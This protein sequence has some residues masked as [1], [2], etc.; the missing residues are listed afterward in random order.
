MTMLA[1]HPP[2]LRHPHFVLGGSPVVTNAAGQILDD[3]D[4]YPFGGERVV[5]S[6]SGNAYKFTGKERDAESGLDNFGL[7]YNSSSLGR[8]MSP[9]PGNISGFLYQNDPQSWN[10]Y[11]YARNN[12]LKY[13]DPDGDVYRVCV[14][15]DDNKQQCTDVSDEEFAQLQKDPGAGISLRN[16]DIYVTD[17]NGNQVKVG[18]YWQTDVD[19]PTG[20]AETLA[21][22]GAMAE[23][24]VNLAPNGLRT[25]GY[26]VAPPLMVTAE[27]GAGAPSCTGD[28][29]ALAMLPGIGELRE[30]ATL[31]KTG[32]AAEKGEEILQ[33]SGGIAQAAKDFASLGGAEKVYGAT[34]VRT[35]SD[36]TKAVLYNSTSGGGPTI[37][38]QDAAGRTVTKIRY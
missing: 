35:L 25:F 31:L 29:V 33:K 10:G 9:D 38:L 19:L 3:S 8:F 1:H 30:G 22:A 7:R 23:L 21:L 27:C 28:N 37:V 12:P 34:K 36:G 11:A 24:G 2:P 6:G 5:A 14:Q 26:I 13:T 20:A 17:A 15:G 4:Y 18:T 16:G 32:A